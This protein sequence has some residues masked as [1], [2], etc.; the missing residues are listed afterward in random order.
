MKKSEAVPDFQ[1]SRLFPLFFIIMA[2]GLAMI[3]IYA[4]EVKAEQVTLAWDA[5]TEPDLSGY[6]IHLGSAA[7]AY[8]TVIDVG[9]QTRYTVTNL[10][11]GTTY[12]FSVTAYNT[13]GHQSDY[14]NEVNKTVVQQYQLT[15]GKRGP[16]LGTVIGGGINC[17]PDCQSVYDEGSQV[18]LQVT[19]E[20]GSIFTGWSGD[21]CSGVGECVL[22]IWSDKSLTAGLLGQTNGVAKKNRNLQ[23]ATAGSRRIIS[24]SDAGGT[25]PSSSENRTATLSSEAGSTPYIIIRKTD[26]RGTV[27]KAWPHGRLCCALNMRPTD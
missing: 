25:A 5:N 14:S 22:T 12:F 27:M 8:N 1:Q 19:P 15:V 4:W 10:N 21:D 20:A 18:T 6:K 26:R 7:H 23:G 2:L 13:Q 16:G 9:N 17:G 3:P 24:R 11:R